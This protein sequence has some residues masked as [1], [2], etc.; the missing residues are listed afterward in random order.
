LCQALLRFA[1]ARL[2]D[3]TLFTDSIGFCEPGA[4]LLVN[5]TGCRES[6]GM[7]VVSRR[8]RLHAHLKSNPSLLR[9]DAHRSDSPNSRDDLIEQPSNVWPLPLKKVFEIVPTAGVRLVTIRKIASA[10][11]ASP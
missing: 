2:L 1:T 6:E 9:K 5:F 4:K 10:L 11:L 8:N 7:N 3:M